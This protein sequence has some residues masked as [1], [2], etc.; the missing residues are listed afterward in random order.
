MRYKCLVAYDG[1]LFSGWQRQAKA[2]T[3]QHVIEQGLSKIYKAPITIHGASRTDAGVHALGQVFHFDTETVLPQNKCLKILNHQMPEDVRLLACEPCA[4][5]FHARYDVVKKTYRY[6]LYMGEYDVFKAAYAMHYDRLPDLERMQA[7]A[8]TWLGQ[9]DFRAFMA[10]GSDKVITNRTIYRAD[11]TRHDQVVRFT[12][13]GNGFL[14]HM[15]R[16]MVGALLDVSEGK[17]T[18]EEMVSDFETGDRNRF[19]RTAPANGLYLT[20]TLYV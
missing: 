18:L 19:K 16:I 8:T 1:R 15:V 20:E 2:R 13:T 9:H 11:I 14:Y 17:R 5:A 10:S 12:V 4:E 3:V 7:L 6:D